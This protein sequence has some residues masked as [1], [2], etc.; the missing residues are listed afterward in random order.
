MKYQIKVTTEIIQE[1]AKLFAKSEGA[2]RALCCPVALAGKAALGKPVIVKG[3]CTD[4]TG[5]RRAQFC[6][7]TSGLPAS[8]S[9]FCDVKIPLSKEVT[10]IIREYDCGNPMSE[11]EFEI[12]VP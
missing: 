7:N 6:F 9:A 5:L 8:S 12:E 1:S 3:T 2:A 11:F 4:D 10:Q